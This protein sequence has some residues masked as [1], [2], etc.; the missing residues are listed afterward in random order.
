LLEFDHATGEA[1]AGIAG[2]LGDIVVGAGVHDHALA[3]DVGGGAVADGCAVQLAV[4][5]G[6]AFVVGHQVVA[7]A[8]VVLALAGATVVAAIGVEVAAGAGGVGRAA[9][10]ELV[11]VEA[12]FAARRQAAD[13]AGDVDMPV[14]HFEAQL[15]AGLVAFGRLQGGGGGGGLGLDVRGRGVHRLGRLDFGPGPGGRVARRIGLLGW[16]RASGGPRVHPRGGEP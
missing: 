1:V 16:I 10:A 6:H 3:D 9:V 13:L 14:G 15:A 2:G 8:H 5:L 7:V 12:V 11:H 4:D